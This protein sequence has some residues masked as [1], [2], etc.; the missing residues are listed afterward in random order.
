[1]RGSPGAPAPVPIRQPVMVVYDGTP[2]AERALDAAAALAEG[3]RCG[4]VVALR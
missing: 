4:L 1:M 3:M 2:A